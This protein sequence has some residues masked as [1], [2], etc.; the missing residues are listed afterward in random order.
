MCVKKDRIIEA[1]KAS[2]MEENQAIAAQ[3]EIGKI[4]LVGCTTFR[5]ETNKYLMRCVTQT[6]PST[7]EEARKMAHR[8]ANMLR[9]EHNAIIASE[10]NAQRFYQAMYRV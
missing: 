5:D 1:L 3:I 8:L 6:H 9:I 4:S 7:P 2:G 10:R